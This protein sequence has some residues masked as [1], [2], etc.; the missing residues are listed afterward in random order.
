MSDLEY[1]DIGT[2]LGMMAEKG[3]DSLEYAELATAEDV[4]KF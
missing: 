4:A 3:N 1:L 2:I